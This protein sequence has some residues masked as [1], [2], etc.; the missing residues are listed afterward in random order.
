MTICESGVEPLEFFMA[1]EVYKIIERR[2]YT[3]DHSSP[4]N[5]SH[6]VCDFDLHNAH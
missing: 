1:K 4:L 3:E 5:F 2:G 6:H